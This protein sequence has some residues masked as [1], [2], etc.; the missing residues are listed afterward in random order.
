MNY[1]FTEKNS[2]EGNVITSKITKKKLIIIGG[3]IIAVIIIAL[4]ISS[5]IPSKFE[6][7]KS[8]CVQ[9]AGMVSGSGDYFI[10]DTDPDIYL[11]NAQAN[12]LEAI[13]YANEAICFRCTLL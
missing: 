9:I 6:R 13:Q 4:V 2:T 10:I 11:P 3:I 12:A 5:M 8:E 1:Q 7:V